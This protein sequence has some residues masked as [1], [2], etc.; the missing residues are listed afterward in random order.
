MGFLTAC[1]ELGVTASELKHHSRGSEMVRVSLLGDTFQDGVSSRLLAHLA[2]ELG[3]FQMLPDLDQFCT[4]L[5]QA[6]QH[7]DNN[8]SSGFPRGPSVCVGAFSPRVHRKKRRAD[9]H[10]DH[11]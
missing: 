4:I 6:S 10:G 2:V 1:T 9:C 3:F 5:S 11:L 7:R 8:V